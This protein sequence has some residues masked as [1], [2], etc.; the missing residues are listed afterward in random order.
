M[1]ADAAR[2]T[3]CVQAAEKEQ[4]AGINLRSSTSEVQLVAMDSKDLNARE[5]VYDELRCVLA[6][7]RH[8][9]RTPKQKLKM[10]V[11]GRGSAPSVPSMPP[12]PAALRIDVPSA[13]CGRRPAQVSSP[14]FLDLLMRHIDSKGKQAKLKSPNQLQEL[15]EVTTAEL[16]KMETGVAEE[17]TGEADDVTSISSKAPG[18][19]PPHPLPPAHKHSTPQCVNTV[20]ARMCACHGCWVPEVI[21]VIAITYYKYIMGFRVYR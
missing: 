2:L 14:P 19:P 1:A 17:A 7:I 5:S 9:D 13:G 3:A 21:G 4:E 10:K 20:C 8:G 18:P 15:L 6:V 16:A 12:L 11:R